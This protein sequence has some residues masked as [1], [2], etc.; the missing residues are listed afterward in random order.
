MGIDL[1]E[2]FPGETNYARRVFELNAS[3]YKF[4]NMPQ[5]GLDKQLLQETHFVRQLRR[6]VVISGELDTAALHRFPLNDREV[7][8]EISGVQ[9]KYP[10]ADRQVRCGMN[11]RTAYT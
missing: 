2:M 4:Q 11:T 7:G 3:A 6:E 8:N 1:R 5:L 9:E 10:I